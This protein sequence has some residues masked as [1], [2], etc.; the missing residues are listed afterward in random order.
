M[1][2]A[3][4]ILILAAI[5]LPAALGWWLARPFA[6]NI[7]LGATLVGGQLLVVPF[8]HSVARVERIGHDP[9]AMTAVWVYAG[10]AI[11]AASIV[12]ALLERSAK[13]K[14]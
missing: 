12:F 4:F 11:L 7:R 8:F 2:M 3:L 5:G 10:G 9:D 14:L 1:D 13:E 6:R